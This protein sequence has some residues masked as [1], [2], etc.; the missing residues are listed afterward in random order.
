M[1]SAT[2]NPRA[3]YDRAWFRSPARIA[4]LRAVAARWRGTPFLCNSN[5]PGPNGGVSCQKLA[6]EIYREAGFMD[7]AVPAA[8]MAHARFSRISLLE[9][10]IDGRPEMLSLDMATR[11][12]PRPGDL[13]GFRIGHVVHHLGIM[14]NQGEFVH[15][16]DRMGCRFCPLSD[17]TFSGRLARIWVPVELESAVIEHTVD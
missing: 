17:P 1:K 6:A 8:P 11:P 13:L 9:R 15:V 10:W 16:L 14:L 5:T 12:W 7:V 4:A 3:E 2:R